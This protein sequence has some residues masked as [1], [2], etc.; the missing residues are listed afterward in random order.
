MGGG[1]SVGTPS[2][3][4]RTSPSRAV[5]RGGR[6]Q[7]DV[8]R[9][10]PP[11]EPPAEWIRIAAKPSSRRSQLRCTSTSWTRRSG[12]TESRVESRP[13]VTCRS[14]ST[15]RCGSCRRA[16]ARPRS[17]VTTRAPARRRRS[18]ISR[19]SGPNHAPTPG[20]SRPADELLE[21]SSR[22]A[23]ICWPTNWNDAPIRAGSTSSARRSPTRARRASSAPRG[24]RAAPARPEVVGV[25]V[26]GTGAG[27]QPGLAD[28]HG[29]AQRDGVGLGSTRRSTSGSLELPAVSTRSAARPSSRWI[30]S[31]LDLDLLDPGDVEAAVVAAQDAAV[32]AEHLAVEGE[33]AALPVEETRY[34]RAEHADEREDPERDP[35]AGGE[36][37]E[38]REDQG[39]DRLGE[40]TP[41]TTLAGCRRR[42]STKGR[43]L[44]ACAG[45]GPPWTQTRIG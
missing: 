21:P 26:R 2:T 10:S 42:G 25:V 7:R 31:R 33:G 37:R 17:A 45:S 3:P 30:G 29:G 13:R 5:D 34:T 39:L 14:S 4:G 6:E 18:A 11:V 9:P 16:R 19:Q 1:V 8:T 27:S 35:P 22:K 23:V 40:G 44:G 38:H 41:R 36:P 20:R 43:A 28:A 32:D 12:T 15:R 24:P